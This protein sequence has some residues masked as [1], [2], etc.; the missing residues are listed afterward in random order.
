M[1]RQ[2]DFEADPSAAT[3]PMALKEDRLELEEL[4]HGFR[5]PDTIRA[6]TQQLYRRAESLQAPLRV[7]EVCGGHTHTIMKYGLQQLLPDNIEF[8]H[9]P[10]CPV[11]II[12]K[13]R[14]DQA[15]AL[16]QRDNT[17]LLTLGDM[18]RVPGSKDSLVK[19]R[20]DGYDIR[21]LYSPLDSLTIAQH[22]PD[23]QVVFFAIG[24][25]TTTPMTAA[26]LQKIEQLGISNLSLHINH[27]MVPPAVDAILSDQSCEV[28]ALIAPS[29]VSVISGAKIYRPLLDKYNLPMVV[30][31][32]EPVDVLQSLLMLVNQQI[33]EEPQ[34]ENQYSRAVSW[35]GN[36]KAQQ[37]INRYFEPRQAFRW[38]GLGD[39]PYSSL[40]LRNKYAHYDA[41]RLFFD[42][43]PVKPIDDHKLCLCGEIL[44]GRAKP[45]DC[46]VFNRGC[47][48]QR[49][50]GSCM[51][52]SEG[53]CNAYY[54]YAKIDF[55][56]KI[57]E[58]SAK[59]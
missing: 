54:R 38:R 18:L 8:I 21:A 26:V 17:I 36:E 22:N 12:P 45:Q 43:V 15:I 53:A 14:I 34:L 47:D 10:G 35:Q 55:Q 46:K 20:A 6:L 58:S 2:N 23:K 49:P 19:V 42:N 30:S 50:L 44:R 41:E 16:A 7:M 51:V 31:G 5:D 32:F 27:V 25:E 39:I 33:A 52:S 1:M 11:C 48:P 59:I 3:V 28:N 57:Q 24:F 4:Y 13:E 40:Q 37:L 9:G 29:H 56:P